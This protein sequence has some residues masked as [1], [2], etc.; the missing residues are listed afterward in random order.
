MLPPPNLLG[1]PLI[2]L[3]S[4]DPFS[5]GRVSGEPVIVIPQ[6]CAWWNLACKGG[7]H[8]ANS[9]LSAITKSIAS[10]AEMLLSQIVQ[11][12]DESSTVPLTDPTY[13]HV[14]FGFL[15]LAA[16]LIGVVLCVALIVA[17]LR[18]DA[19]TLARAFVGVG[20]A[21]L[22][23]ALYIVFAQ[24]LVALDDWLSHGVV[25]VTGYNLSDAIERIAVGFHN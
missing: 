17:S 23:G 8:L 12:I 22:G 5:V 24:L 7:E 25:R 4:G 6:D 19:G 18:R 10:G 13:Q 16:T 15:G 9:G 20:I 3:G 1:P 14:Y 2:D 11:V 21:S